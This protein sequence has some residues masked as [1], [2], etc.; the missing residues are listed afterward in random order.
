MLENQ[1]GDSESHGQAQVDPVKPNSAAKR[2]ALEHAL[3][4][5]Q[6]ANLRFPIVRAHFDYL[7]GAGNRAVGEFGRYLA[8]A[9]GE[10]KT[11]RPAMNDVV[12]AAFC[13]N[14]LSPLEALLKHQF[15]GPIHLVSDGAGEQDNPS[16]VLWSLESDGSSTYRFSENLADHPYAD[17]LLKN[18][19]QEIP[20]LTNFARLNAFGAGRVWL[21]VGDMGSMPGLAYC[22]YRQG[23]DL[24]PDPV[25]MQTAAYADAKAT[26]AR[27]SV[28]WSSRKPIAF[29][30]GQTTG[31][32]SVRGDTIRNWDEL[33][34][35]QLCRLAQSDAAQGLLDAGLSGLAQIPS[36]EHR[37]AIRD[38]GLLKE[39]MHWSDFQQWKFQI[40][41]DGNT[42]A[43]ASMFTKLY[44][45]SPILKVKSPLC[46][47]QWYY[48]R[49]VPWENYVPVEADMSDLLEKITWLRGHDEHAW[50]I[51][52]NARRLAFS[53]TVKRE[54][55]RAIPTIRKALWP[56]AVGGSGGSGFSETRKAKGDE[57][58]DTNMRRFDELDNAVLEQETFGAR[59]LDLE[60][61][62]QA[63]RLHLGP[64]PAPREGFINVDKFKNSQTREF[65]E[66]HPQ[67][68]IVYPFAELPWPIADCSVDYI[69]HEDFIEHIPQKNQFLVLAEALRVLK[70]GAI[71]RVSTP[72]LIQSMKTRSDFARGFAGVHVSEWEQWGHVALLTRASLEE[73]ALLV[74]Y[75]C[76]YFTAKSQSMSPFASDDSRPHSDR[77]QVLG[78]IFADLLK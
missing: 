63:V 9:G 30:R 19:V 44:S 2:A 27:N 37:Q 26:Y 67:D 15:G 12:E 38:E 33:P 43:W 17:V 42:N 35:V 64:G 55:S 76:V 3:V 56:S 46:F 60:D 25:F 4:G 49:L 39:Y 74:G 58:K 69:Y 51:G 54:T 34:R 57:K 62:K 14:A 31:W 18:W 21:N 47:R 77:D 32:Y 29:W 72:C 53:M 11:N 78:N 70:P 40:D 5:M 73:M 28:A 23:Y 65:F 22:D 61:K 20:V 66:R 6:P 24:L 16:I 8:T 75:R 52:E 36:E 13:M 48:D 71:H 41:I 45:G 68:Y 50:Q 59:V 10:L 7:S 1:T